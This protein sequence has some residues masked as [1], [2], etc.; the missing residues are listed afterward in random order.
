MEKY[1]SI[2][3]M[4]DNPFRNR[5]VIFEIAPLG[6]VARVV[7]IDTQTMTEI[8]IQCPLNTPQ[9]LMKSNALKRLEFVMRKRGFLN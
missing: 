1:T 4:A 9:S 8:S 2:R 7:A 5:E 6:N 3:P